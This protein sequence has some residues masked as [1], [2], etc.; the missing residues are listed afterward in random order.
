MFHFRAEIFSMSHKL[1]RNIIAL[2]SHF[3][4]EGAPLCLPLVE[5]RSDIE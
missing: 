5:V 4:I 3:I 2:V 1:V